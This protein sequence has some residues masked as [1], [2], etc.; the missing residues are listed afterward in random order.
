MKNPY[1]DIWREGTI[2]PKLKQ[3]HE[4]VIVFDIERVIRVRKSSPLKSRITQQK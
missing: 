2:W 1:N 3:N 4:L